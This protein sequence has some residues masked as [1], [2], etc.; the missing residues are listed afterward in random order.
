M[1]LVIRGVG[2]SCTFL[3]EGSKLEQTLNISTYLN[4]ILAFKHFRALSLLT[5]P[6]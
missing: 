1:A 5:F 6:V 4:L 3:L 2:G